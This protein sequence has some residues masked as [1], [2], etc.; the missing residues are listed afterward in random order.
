MSNVVTNPSPKSRFQESNQNIATHRELV[1]SNPLQRALDFAMLHY[2][3][4]L[5]NMHDHTNPELSRLI[6]TKLVGAM[7]FIHVLR[8]LAETPTMPSPRADHNLNPKA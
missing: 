1:S 5:Y 2:Q 3:Q 4:N 6:G 8:N 7:E